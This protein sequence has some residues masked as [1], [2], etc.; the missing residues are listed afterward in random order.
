MSVEGEVCGIESDAREPLLA[1]LEDGLRRGCQGRLRAE[2]PLSLGH[3]AAERHRVVLDRGR[4]VS[5]AMWHIVEMEADGVRI[6]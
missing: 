2:Y 4:P 3:G 6:P 5:H 1:W